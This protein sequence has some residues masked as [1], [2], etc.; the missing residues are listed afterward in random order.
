ME[1]MSQE[2]KRQIRDLMR[3]KISLEDQLQ[4]ATD[5]RR[6]QRLED[7]LYEVKDTLDK[8]T[9]GVWF[10]DVSEHELQKEREGIN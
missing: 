5:D 8:L 9:N 2:K 3:Q 4:I 10:E 1:P 7:D 6:I